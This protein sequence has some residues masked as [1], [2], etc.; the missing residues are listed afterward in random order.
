MCQY[1]I[2]KT[3]FDLFGVFQSLVF[4]CLRVEINTAILSDC[5]AI[6]YRVVG[7]SLEQE[8]ILVIKTDFR[9]TT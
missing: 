1:R 4:T 6:A 3:L 9:T 5:S 8:S 7:E 2:E